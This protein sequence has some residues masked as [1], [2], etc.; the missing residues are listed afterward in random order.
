MLDPDV[1]YHLEFDP[2]AAAQGEHRRLQSLNPVLNRTNP[3]VLQREKIN[4]PQQTR[5]RTSPSPSIQSRSQ[6]G[7]DDLDTQPNVG[8]IFAAM[9]LPEVE[10]FKD[11]QG[12]GFSEFVTRFDMKYGNL[13][14]RDDMLAH[15][16]FSK[17]E[18]YPKAVAEALPKY[19]REGSF[20]EILEALRSK[21]KTNESANQMKAYMEFKHLKMTKDV[22]RYCLELE[23][24][25]R[26]AYPVASEEDLSRTRAGELV[27]QLTGWPEYLHFFTT[28]ELAP[29]ESAYEMVKAMAQRCERSKE[30]AASMRETSDA[31]RQRQFRGRK[32]HCVNSREKDRQQQSDTSNMV[33]NNRRTET[34]Q[35]TPIKKQMKCYNCNELGHFERDCTRRK[36]TEKPAEKEKYEQGSKP[37]AKMFTASLSKWICGSVG[38]EKGQDELVGLQMVANVRLLGLSRKALLD[39]GS[40]ISIIPSKYSKQACRVVLI[41][42]KTWKKFQST[43]KS[44]F[45]THQAIR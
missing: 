31:I 21:F 15:L 24:L 44:Q 40:Q 29:K 45:M 1:E 17:L 41:W 11:P 3:S 43:S 25:T 20:Q 35:R 26:K 13:G 12:R 4:S 36:M 33:G 5:A 39:T 27:S 23:S 38:T 28:M 8:Y 42:M 22:T 14:L 16:L 37:T 6:G 19:I 7:F 18:G 2:I 30:I 9:A 34:K 32:L 10:I